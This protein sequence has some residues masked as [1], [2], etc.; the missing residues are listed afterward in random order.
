MD[1]DR[2]MELE[3][4]GIDASDF[5]LLDVNELHSEKKTPIP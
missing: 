3:N 5:S 4:V 2:E 1:F